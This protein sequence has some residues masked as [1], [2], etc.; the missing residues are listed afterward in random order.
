MGVGERRT[1]P[2]DPEK[3]SENLRG[4]VPAMYLLTPF[5]AECLGFGVE[6]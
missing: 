5:G 3:N 1:D 2:E 6:G 4:V